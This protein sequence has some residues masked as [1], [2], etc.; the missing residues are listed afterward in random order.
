M[1]AF[2]VELSDHDHGRIR[3]AT[4]GGF[5]PP[6]DIYDLESDRS[7][8]HGRIMKYGLQEGSSSHVPQEPVE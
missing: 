5:G 2:D 1:R 3:S 4:G 8:P 6:G 7:G